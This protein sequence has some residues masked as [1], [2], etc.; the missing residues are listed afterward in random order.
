MDWW[1]K[2]EFCVDILEIICIF[3]YLLWNCVVL[4]FNSFF[5][6]NEGILVKLVKKGVFGFVIFVNM[7]V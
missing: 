1:K 4:Y 3:W 5:Y 7:V 2:I 6:I